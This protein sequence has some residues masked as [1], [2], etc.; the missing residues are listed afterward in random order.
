MSVNKY[1]IEKQ[2]NGYGTF[3]L[4]PKAKSW[5]GTVRNLSINGKLPPFAIDPTRQMMEMEE[6]KE[7]K[8]KAK[9][10]NPVVEVIDP[11][12]AQQYVSTTSTVASSAP[13]TAPLGPRK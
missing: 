6:E 9:E 10:K 13:A 4:G 12:S 8:T 7:V 3:S 1:L 11:P 5:L 2:W